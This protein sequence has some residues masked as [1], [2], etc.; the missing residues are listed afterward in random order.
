MTSLII[1]NDE[2]QAYNPY[3]DNYMVLSTNDYTNTSVSEIQTLLEC[4]NNSHGNL[5]M[6]EVQEQGYDMI[7]FLENIGKIAIHKVDH[8]GT[9]YYTAIQKVQDEDNN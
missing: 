7:S 1:R 5:V 9:Y 2:N 8:K 4:I 6:V 3:I